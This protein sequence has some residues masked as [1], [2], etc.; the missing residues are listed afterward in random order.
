MAGLGSGIGRFLAPLRSGL[1]V[2]LAL[3]RRD[4]WT[5]PGLTGISLRRRALPIV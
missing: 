2:T 3:L 5:G 4:T 1:T